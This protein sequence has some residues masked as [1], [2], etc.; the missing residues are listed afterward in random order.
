MKFVS[1]LL[2][3]AMLLTFIPVSAFGATE[4][5]TETAPVEEAKEDDGPNWGL[6]ILMLLLLVLI[7]VGTI[8]FLKKR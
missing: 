1:L 8:Y 5:V 3:I 6:V 4:P 2:I 7:Q